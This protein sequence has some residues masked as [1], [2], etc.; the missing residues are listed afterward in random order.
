[1]GCALAAVET[2][3]H[4]LFECK[5]NRGVAARE[6]HPVAIRSNQAMSVLNR[7]FTRKDTEIIKHSDTREAHPSHMERN[8]PRRT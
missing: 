7:I 6:R 2:M 1:M 8:T 4:V 5:G 3:N